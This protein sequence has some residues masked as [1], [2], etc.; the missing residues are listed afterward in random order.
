MENSKNPVLYATY[1]EEWLLFYY[2]GSGLTEI[3]KAPVST[4]AFI[5]VEKW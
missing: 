5:Y 3:K 2:Y 1:Y 4:E